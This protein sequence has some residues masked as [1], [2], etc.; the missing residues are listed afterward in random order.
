M[1]R[2][3]FTYLWFGSGGGGGGTPQVLGR[4][5]PLPPPQEASGQ[6]LVG[7][8]VVG[9]QNRGVAPPPGSGCIRQHMS[10]VHP[11]GYFLFLTIFNDFHRLT[12]VFRLSTH[13]LPF[14]VQLVKD[15]EAQPHIA[16]LVFSSLPRW[17]PIHRGEPALSLWGSAQHGACTAHTPCVYWGLT[18][19]SVHSRC[20]IVLF[21]GQQVQG[22]VLPSSRG[23][24]VLLRSKRVCI[25]SPFLLPRSRASGGKGVAW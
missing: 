23:W 2:L 17:R 4:Q 7:G 9:V 22:Y 18:Q 8:G 16:P 5:L 6:Q 15:L 13:C 24:A 11:N 12:M 19:C 1:P 3:C 21:H 14:P 20:R 25:A 10:G